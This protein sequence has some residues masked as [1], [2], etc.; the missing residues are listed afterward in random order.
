MHNLP[1]ARPGQH[2]EASRIVDVALASDEDCRCALNLDRQ[3]LSA[4]VNYLLKW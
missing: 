3:L 4:H 1:R 2:C